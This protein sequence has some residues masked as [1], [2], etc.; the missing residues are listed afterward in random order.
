M[1]RRCDARGR[2]GGRDHQRAM[3]GVRRRTQS[4]HVRALRHARR[5]EICLTHSSCTVKK[6]LIRLLDQRR[7]RSLETRIQ[8][9]NTR[10]DQLTNA[11]DQ[12]VRTGIF[13][14]GE[15]K[16]RF[17]ERS[18]RQTGDRRAQDELLPFA[19]D[20]IVKNIDGRR[21]DRFVD[22]A[23]NTRRR[24]FRLLPRKSNERIFTWRNFGIVLRSSFYVLTSPQV[25]CRYRR[26]YLRSANVDSAICTSL[27]KS[28]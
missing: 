6:I 9:S 20:L 4:D 27:E 7:G 15:K 2:R 10:G 1:V 21:G 5:I 3:R 14:L 11:V 12:G 26:F 18:K 13:P 28:I 19:Q 25:E 16:E 17:D 8:L 22:D 24:T 23:A